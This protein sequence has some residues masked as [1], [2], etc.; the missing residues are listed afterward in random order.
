MNQAVIKS[1]EK[2]YTSIQN[3]NCQHCH[4]CCGPV[5]WFEPEELMIRDY[6]EKNKIKRIL[7]TIEEFEQNHM[8]CPYLVDDRCII[9][10]VRPIACR[11]QGNIS[12]LKCKSSNDHRLMS[13]KELS[14]IREEFV[15]L[16]K[17]TNGMNI[18]Y[19]TLKLKTECI[20]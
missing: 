9:Y 13:E 6:L 20:S 15:K 8:R 5:I 11:L 7:W 2:I 19:S 10:P 1:L 12:E 17:Q 16:I 4:Q 18:F 3:F 14:D